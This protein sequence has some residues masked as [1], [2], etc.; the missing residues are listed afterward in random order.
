MPLVRSAALL[1]TLIL[2]AAGCLSKEDAPA[3]EDLSSDQDTG[4]IADNQT[5]A[6]DGRGQIAAF[7]ESN[8]TVTNG[9]DAMEHKHDY[10]RGETRRLIGW[11]EGI[12]VPL[13]LIPD[14]KAPGTAIADFDL[15]D[16]LLVFEGTDHLEFTFNRANAVWSL[17]TLPDTG[18][19]AITLFVDYLTAADE[20]GQFHPAGQ[21]KVGEPIIIPV[22][23][24][25]ADMPHQTKSLWL[26]RVY[27]GEANEWEFNFTIT[28]VKGQEV[29][30]W[31]PHPD[32][33]ADRPER[34]VFDGPFRGEYG[35]AGDQTLYGTDANWFYPD[36]IISYGTESVTV[37]ITRGAWGGPGPEPAADEFELQVNNASYIPKVGNGDP[38]GLHLAPQNADGTTYVFDVPVDKAGYDT[39]YGQ[40]SRWAFRFVP[41][42]NDLEREALLLGSGA[43]PWA[44]DY[45]ATVVAK[46]RSVSGETLPN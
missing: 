3:A 7:Q 15:P 37:T 26:F 46:G 22:K 1:F 20:P 38:A 19:P 33:Y 44:L 8:R 17:G 21:G 13:P 35:G 32:L 25:Q 42:D 39:P 36:K 4:V 43:E 18:H 34:V 28:A 2:L 29:V 30:D 14:G 45:T 27:T 24:I 40:K 11:D 9:T 41:I 12:L 31:P 23:S 5:A 16:D 10:W 6:P